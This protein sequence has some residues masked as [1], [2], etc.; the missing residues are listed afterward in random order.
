MGRIE[1]RYWLSDTWASQ[2]GSYDCYVPDK[3]SQLEISLS[4]ATVGMVSKAESAVL[5]LNE[6]DRALTD[7]EPLARLLLRSEAVG[8]SRIEG[9]EAPA[10]K[11]LEVELLQREGKSLRLDSTEATVLANIEAMQQG[12]DACA[13]DGL[14]VKHLCDMNGVLLKNTHMAS[15]SGRIRTVQNWIGGDGYSALN[16]VYIPPVPE[17]VP[18]LLDD[19]VSFANDSPLPPLAVAGIAHAQ[20]ENIHPFVDG[21]GRTGRALIHVIMRHRGL[22][23]GIVPPVSLVLATDRK[24]YLEHLANFRCVD[25]DDSRLMDSIDQ[26]VGYYARSVCLACERAELFDDR[27]SLI[28][29]TW[30][31]RGGVRA[32]SAED[33]LMKALIGSPVVSVRSASELI[34]RSYQATRL[35]IA[36][37]VSK[38]VLSQNSKNRRSRIFVARDVIDAFTGFERALAVPGGDTGMEK[39]VRAVLMRPGFKSLKEIAPKVTIASSVANAAHSRSDGN[40]QPG[41]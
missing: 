28:E 31:S 13:Q 14:S 22:S 10:R 40:P 30:R 17:L 6:A 15:F 29:S 3:L 37:L 16:A 8:S 5:R 11:L 23:N 26:W 32:K 7:T 35:A 36:S 27:L 1:R 18:G 39:P 2:S 20:F 34:G 38:G 19:L 41:R 24:G 9:L 25:G 12:I 4:Q 21:N 33:L